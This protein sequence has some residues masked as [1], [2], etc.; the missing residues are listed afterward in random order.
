MSES[1]QGLLPGQDLSAVAAAQGFHVPQA[2]LTDGDA[3][4][5]S[6]RFCERN[7][8]SGVWRSLSK[9]R[10]EFYLLGGSVAEIPQSRERSQALACLE[11][12]F[13]WARAAL[14]RDG[15]VLHGCAE[16]DPEAEPH[17]ACTP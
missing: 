13:F 2:R 14:V 1:L 11:Q 6:R 12:A 4:D 16:P 7:A 17:S 15:V 8:E 9:L 5:L 10:T 3:A